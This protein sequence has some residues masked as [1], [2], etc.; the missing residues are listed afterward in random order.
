M[1]CA[2]N[3]VSKDATVQHQGGLM[4]AR[5]RIKWWSLLGAVDEIRDTYAPTNG[6]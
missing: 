1:A 3:L 5:C 4:D 2:I 6:Q